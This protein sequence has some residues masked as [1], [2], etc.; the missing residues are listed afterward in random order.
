MR[1]RNKLMSTIFAIAAVL[2]MVCGAL[3]VFASEET[4]AESPQ[5]NDEAYAEYAG[6]IFSGKD[7]WEGTL[8]ITIRSIVDGK[9]EWTFTDSF[10]DHTLFQVVEDTAIQDNKASFDIKGKDVQHEE[11]SFSYQGELELKDGKVSVLFLGGAVTSES[12]EGGSSYHA[13][14]ALSGSGSSNQVLLDKAAEGPYTSYTVQAGDSIHSIAEEY[15]ISTKDLA[16]LNQIVILETAKSHG[17]EFD[18][19]TEYTKHLYPGEKL[20]VPVK[21]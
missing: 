2:V 3:P 6:Y 9:M 16:I 1:N 15:G 12:S 19:V 7:P 18:D 5:V 17:L 20:L 10:E 4:A 8:T 21:N 14:G 11:V 13:A